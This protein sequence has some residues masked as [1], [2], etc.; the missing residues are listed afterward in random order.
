MG[1]MGLV[2]S[3]VREARLS[4]CRRYRYTLGRRWGDKE[5]RVTWIMLNPSV[6]DAEIDDATI[7][8]CMKFT[9]R[10]GHDS[11]MVV[12]LFAYRATDPEELVGVEDPVGPEN[13]HWVRQ[14]CHQA[15]LI[16]AAWGAI[17]K[18]LLGAARAIFGIIGKEGYVLKCLGKTKNG[19]PRHP[20][21]LRDD[22][23][24]LGWN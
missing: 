15:P 12:N 3:L 4:D 2:G 14:A 8:K 5:K 10:L 9:E 22:S 1:L 20:L 7:K 13:G 18:Q 19:M 23:K 11:M 17:K 24:L 16:I 21:Y 6:A